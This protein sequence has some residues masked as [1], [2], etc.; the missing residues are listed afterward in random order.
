MGSIILHNQCKRPGKRFLQ[1]CVPVN[2][3][4]QCFIPRFVLKLDGSVVQGDAEEA[5]EHHATKGARTRGKAAPVN[6]P[7]LM[8]TTYIQVRG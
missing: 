8:N 3:S 2:S 5:P 7:W 6:L 4:V 1:A